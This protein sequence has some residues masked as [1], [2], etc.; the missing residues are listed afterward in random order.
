MWTVANGYAQVY[1]N[2]IYNYVS[3]KKLCKQN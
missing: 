3:G 1:T 2:F